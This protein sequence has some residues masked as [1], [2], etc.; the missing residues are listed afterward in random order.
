MRTLATRFVSATG[1]IINFGK[2]DTVITH[3]GHIGVILAI[4]M[5]SQKLQVEFRS[6]DEPY[7][8]WYDYIL[9]DLL[10]KLEPEVA[11][12]WKQSTMKGK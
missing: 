8:G 12:I 6:I 9:P 11:D 1:E 5:Q 10:T 2:G 4:D 7:L 3:E